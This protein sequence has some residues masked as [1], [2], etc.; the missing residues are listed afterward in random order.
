MK[1]LILFLFIF[2]SLFYFKTS[3]SKEFEKKSL[4][5]DKKNGILFFY[6]SGKKFS[7]DIRKDSNCIILEKDKLENINKVSGKCIFNKYHKKTLV[8]VS[9]VNI[10]G[11]N[12]SYNIF[13]TINSQK[14]KKLIISE[15]TKKKKLSVLN[16]NKYHL[17][18]QDFEEIF[19]NSKLVSFYDLM[20]LL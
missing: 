17:I 5:I 7:S 20:K 8:R 15:L 1:N 3:N 11:R 18:N 13:F 10:N 6:D 9:R 14:N 12:K 19:V 16:I 4:W 2:I